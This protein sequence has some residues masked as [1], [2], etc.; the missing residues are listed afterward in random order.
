MEQF[1]PVERK[2][3]QDAGFDMPKFSA[4]AAALL[5]VLAASPTD[6]SAAERAGIVSQALGAAQQEVAKSEP[7]PFS[8]LLGQVMQ[9]LEKRGVAK[10]ADEAVAKAIPI[11]IDEITKKMGTLGSAVDAEYKRRGIK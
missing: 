11:A 5:A 1:K 2:E 7:S 8:N 6:A 4:P 9:E 3:T 10:Q